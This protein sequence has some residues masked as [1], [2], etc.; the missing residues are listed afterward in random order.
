M[1][2]IA[3]F[4]AIYTGLLPPAWAIVATD[5]ATATLPSLPATLR[6]H[7]YY[8]RFVSAADPS[9]DNQHVWLR[10]W[11]EAVD[12][13]RSR[14][15]DADM[16][17]YLAKWLRTELTQAAKGRPFFVVATSRSNHFPF[18]RVAGVPVTGSDAWPDRMRDT[19]GYADAAMGTLL[20][21]L[22]SEP[23]FA[24]TLVIVTGDHGYPLGEHGNYAMYQSVH[25]ETTGVPLVVAGDHPKLQRLRGV[26]TQEPASHLDIAPTV[27]D[28]LGIDPSGAWMGRSL[29]AGGQGYSWTVKDGLWASEIGARRLLA[30]A[31]GLDTI[32]HWQVFDRLVDWREDHP[33]E[34][35]PSDR[36]ALADVS[37]LAGWMYDLY[38]RDRIVPAAL[39]G[40]ER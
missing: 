25:V 16:F 27:L 21:T 7:G 26:V 11:F 10:H 22:A 34:P 24:R 29:V 31:T 3:S 4:M 6:K 15:E 14:E 9:W 23:W 32:A 36:E 28:L 30:R 35:L 37:A 19:M 18:P 33:L 2:T 8:T 40:G 5:F 12:Y 17:A 1:P 20:D 38:R 39:V 13:D